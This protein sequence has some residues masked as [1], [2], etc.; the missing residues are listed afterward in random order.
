MRSCLV[1]IVAIANAGC[2]NSIG[3][4]LADYALG[5]TYA[6]SNAAALKSMP[7]GSLRVRVE[8]QPTE[9]GEDAAYLYVSPLSGQ[10]GKIVLSRSMDDL[11]AAKSAAAAFKQQLEADYPHWERQAVPVRM[12]RGGGEMISRLSQ[13]PYAF[14]VFYQ[15][16]ESGAQALLELEYDARAPQR[17]AWR[18]LVR[19]EHAASVSAP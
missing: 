8:G 7:D 19:D 17:K 4:G 10:I 2:A 6:V 12:G 18:Q 16:S 9:Y 11:A 14:I 15:P 5:E 1:L 3:F 13:D